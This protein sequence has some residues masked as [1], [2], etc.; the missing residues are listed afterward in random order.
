MKQIIFICSLTLSASGFSQT[1]CGYQ[2]KQDSCALLSPKI[3]EVAEVMEVK[4]KNNYLVQ[5]IKQDKKNYLKIIVRDDLGFGKKGSLLLLSS[6]KQIYVKLIKL[7][8]IDKNSAYFLVELNNSYYLD[9]L[10]EF[11]LSK[12]VFNETVEFGVPK[13]DSDQIKKAAE[14]FYGI[15]KDNIWPPTKKL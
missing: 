14:C 8:P 2:L 12:I 3:K 9:N 6:K 5:F 11:G 10:K 13:P 1:P 7:E 15:V 4:I